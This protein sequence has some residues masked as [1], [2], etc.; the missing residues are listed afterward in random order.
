MLDILRGSRETIIIGQMRMLPGSQEYADAWELCREASDAEASSASP[1]LRDQL[2]RLGAIALKLPIALDIINELTRINDELRAGLTVATTL[3]A[4][5]V[6]LT[7]NAADE[8]APNHR[9]DESHRKG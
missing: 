8:A 7:E 5:A 1:V 6:L 3:V 4:E 2:A 9:L